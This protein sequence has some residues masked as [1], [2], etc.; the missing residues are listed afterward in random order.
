MTD[1]TRIIAAV[2][3]EQHLTMYKEDGTTVLIPQ[4]DPRIAGLVQKLVPALENKGEYFLTTEDMHSGANHFAEA[5]KKMNGFVRFF[6]A[7]KKKVQEIT[8][9]FVGDTGEVKPLKVGE[10]PVAKLVISEA[11]TQQ[12]GEDI[13]D[14]AGLTKSQAAVAEIMAHAVTTERHDFSQMSEAE[15][16]DT[17]I[18]AVLADNTIIP[19]VE[20]LSGQ[21]QALA[22]N[23]GNPVGMQKFFERMSTVSRGHSVQ[24]LLKFMEKGELPVADDGCVLV[25][26]RLRSTSE[27]GVYVDEHTKLV[28]QRVGSKVYMDESL[29]DANRSRDCSNGLHVARRDYLQTFSGDICV[30]AKLAP[31]DV[32]AVPHRDARKLRARGYHI[33]ALLSQKDHDNVTNNRPLEDTNLLGNAIAGN[34]VGILEYVHIVDQN[35]SSDSVKIRPADGVPV[36]T[37]ELNPELHG[38]SLDAMQVEE[39]KASTVNA[40][41]V[42]LEAAKAKELPATPVK[43]SVLDD[44]LANWNKAKD[45]GE[46]HEAAKAILAYKKKAKK[47]WAAL[48]FTESLV[49]TLAEKSGD[50]TILP[51]V[52]KATSTKVKV[53]PKPVT[54]TESN[55]KVVKA[56]TKKAVKKTVAKPVAKKPSPLKGTK[57]PT[58]PAGKKTLAEQANE[59]WVTVSQKPTVANAQALADLKKKSKK[60][61]EAL[62]FL[63]P[64]TVAEKLKSILG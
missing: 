45:S 33:I 55:A 59:L 18:V 34:H 22:M 17:T 3:D 35:R 25:Y 8:N 4:G 14:N 13:T 51:A 42:A 10:I 2:V 11:E 43:V 44:L 57:V 6:K 16:E 1:T 62:G 48:G 26:K 36:N 39:V 32:I 63:S 38:N 64:A 20:Q 27:A 61:W 5:E 54:K 58:A 47:S 46:S 7:A 24:D 49:K 60:S 53:P 19:G 31:E 37:V 50:Q 12:N 41:A 28:K 40:G 56:A 29:V 30:L 52:G 15:K 21:M 9:K 23:M